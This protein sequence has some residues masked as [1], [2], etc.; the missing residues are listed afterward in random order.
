MY[1][2][3]LKCEI[4]KSNALLCNE[5][6]EEIVPPFGI[7]CEKYSSFTKL[8]RVT[9]WI[10]RFISRIK[11]KKESGNSLTCTE[12]KMAVLAWIKYIQRRTTRMF[13]KP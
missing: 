2:A 12:L 9:A 1:I 8:I 13:L 4:V 7:D 10:Q 5:N 3:E 11:R 6:T